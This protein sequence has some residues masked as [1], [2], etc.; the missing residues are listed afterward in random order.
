MLVHVSEQLS[1]TPLV[2]AFTTV[3]ELLEAE[4]ASLLLRRSTDSVFSVAASVGMS[5]ELASTVR[6]TLGEGVAGVV[7]ERGTP[8]LGIIARETFLSVPIATERGIEGVLNLSERRGA[9][10]YTSRDLEHATQAAEHI[11]QLMEFS[12]VALRDAL[13]GLHNRAALSESLENEI[14]RSQ[15]L[16][17]RFAL[18]FLDVD[19]L[20]EVND[21]FG[22]QE[23]D[24]LLQAVGKA[25]E[26]V[27]R[28]YDL[29]VRYGGD[30]FV[31]LLTD[32]NE[33]GGPKAQ[34]IRVR[35]MNSLRV[36]SNER[37]M[38]ISA[39]FGIAFWPDDGRSGEEV[40]AAADARMYDDK[41]SKRALR[42]RATT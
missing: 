40:L 17:K 32:M 21:R 30:E 5:P 39:S 38:P 22:H 12:R 3:V 6:V 31:L 1:G 27:G 41:R 34:D 28:P 2:S 19:N 20:K 14:V 9:A 16:R 29:A 36:V 42:V 10:P 37:T 11:G 33:E 8:V 23:G 7:A 4:R 18:V 15:R 35:I 24:Q 25:L 26:G 13:T